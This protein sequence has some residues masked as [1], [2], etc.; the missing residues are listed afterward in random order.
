M[1]TYGVGR[2]SLLA[3]EGQYL[4]L[5]ETGDLLRL[6]LSPKGCVEVERTRLFEAPESW[7]PMVLSH[8]LL[9]VAQNFRDMRSQSGPRLICYDL[10][11]D[12]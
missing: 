9:Y 11:G 6:E 8:G 4:C 10:R 2:G 3:I 7:S 5:G 12:E 1:R